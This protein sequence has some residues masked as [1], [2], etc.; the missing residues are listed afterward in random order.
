MA[1]VLEKELKF[2][3]KR[4]L[5][6]WGRGGVALDKWGSA[7]WTIVF[8]LSGIRTRKTPWKNA[9]AASHASIA[10]SVVSRNTGKTNRSGTGPA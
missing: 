9:Q 1:E 8:V 7:R 2:P 5:D 6:G 10:V 4:S 3:V